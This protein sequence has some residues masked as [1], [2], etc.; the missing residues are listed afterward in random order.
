[1]LLK[2]LLLIATIPIGITLVSCRLFG[3]TCDCNEALY[4]NVCVAGKY[5]ALDS[6]TFARERSNGLIDTL[7]VFTD[8]SQNQKLCFPER[9]GKQ[10]I[11]VH[12]RKVRVDSSAWFEQ[13]KIDCCRFKDTTITF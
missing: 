12:Q 6:I 1:M 2:K 11:L 9:G 4:N 7:I 3:N 13:V 10:R 5:N 8:T